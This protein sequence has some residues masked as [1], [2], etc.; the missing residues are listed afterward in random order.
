MNCPMSVQDIIDRTVNMSIKLIEGTGG[1]VTG[2]AG[3]ETVTINTEA[4]FNVPLEFYMALLQQ[5]K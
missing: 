4:G 5:W 2:K 3:V 1:K